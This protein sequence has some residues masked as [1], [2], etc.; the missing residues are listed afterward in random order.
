MLWDPFSRLKRNNSNE[1]YTHESIKGVCKPNFQHL[2]VTQS[3]LSKLR[4]SALAG[5][6][7]I[8]YINIILSYPPPKSYYKFSIQSCLLHLYGF[9]SKQIAGSLLQLFKACNC[10]LVRFN[11]KVCLVTHHNLDF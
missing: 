5:V 8:L 4:F 3:V 9:H 2:H 6:P 7:L 11:I 1:N 10:L